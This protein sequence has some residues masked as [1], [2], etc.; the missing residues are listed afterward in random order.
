[1]T[2]SSK[3][4]EYGDFQT[5]RKLARDICLLLQKNN[6]NPRSV[7]EPTCGVGAFFIEALKTFLDIETGHGFDVNDEYVQILKKEI[8]K[9]NIV[10][11]H[12]VEVADFFTKNWKSEIN[13]LHE[14]ILIIGNPSWVTN[15]QLGQLQSDNLPT[16]YNKSG[17][18]GLDALTGKSNF[19]ISEWMINQMIDWI[20]EKKGTIAMLCKTSVARKV[21]F[22]AWRQDKKMNT[23]TM[24]IID[25][26]GHFDISA[27][28]CLL[29]ITSSEKKSKECKVYD[30]LWAE[31]PIQ[32]IGL[33]DNFLV[34]DI[35][36]YEK[37]KH[38]IDREQYYQWRTGIKHDCSSVMEV[39]KVGE[40]T[41]ING[42]GEINELEE[43]YLFPL[44]KG[45]D[46]S[47]GKIPKKFML[48][49]QTKVGQETK[50]LKEVAP[51]TW[52]YLLKYE[53]L[54][55]KRGSSIYKG[56]PKFSV[57]GVGDYT[58]T[59]WKVAIPALYKKLD[60]SVIG[61]Y[62]NKI[63]VFDD[64]VNFIALDNEEEARDLAN[65]LNS[66]IAET[67]YNAFVFGDS[68]RPVT[69][70]LLKSLDID[71]LLTQS[72]QKNQYSISKTTRQLQLV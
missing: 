21:L 31:N 14:P 19:D 28:S 44:L 10:V 69:V 29:T 41:Y 30:Y 35:P 63:V 6:T 49:P 17:M 27:D 15:S 16:K 12:K 38:L 67:F 5:P 54:L 55:E 24:H 3:K 1:M 22:S 48:V 4:I 52:N 2:K 56:K 71:E 62:Q 33:R 68:K 7:I 47:N 43:T 34:A 65:I 58:F 20:Q 39:E 37:T 57:F 64:T 72:G 60:F 46:L 59:K 23:A 51:K 66:Q 18:K 9:E 36:S 70:Q 42:L 13:T 53:K 61:P 40:N 45:S 11:S 8:S 50:Y 26:K 32:T 25:S